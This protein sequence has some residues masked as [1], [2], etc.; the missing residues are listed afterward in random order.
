MATYGRYFTKHG[1]EIIVPAMT[2]NM[3]I[4]MIGTTGYVISFI[5]IDISLLRKQT[6]I[7][8]LYVLKRLFRFEFDAKRRLFTVHCYAAHVQKIQKIVKVDH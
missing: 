5:D 6:R 3:R 7:R 1:A 2:D 8:P 4:H